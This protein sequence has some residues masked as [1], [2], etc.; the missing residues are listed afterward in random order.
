MLNAAAAPNLPRRARAVRPIEPSSSAVPA[1]MQEKPAHTSHTDKKEIKCCGNSEIQHEIFCDTSRKSEKH[2]Q[3]REISR[4]SRFTS[5]L[6][7]LTVL[8]YVSSLIKPVI[9]C[10]NICIQYIWYPGETDLQGY[11]T[12]GDWLAGV[13]YPGSQIFELKISI[14]QQ[15]LNQN[16]K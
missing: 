2:E 5:F 7:K 9:I 14:T 6:L 11:D 10:I 16:R 15:I 12:R 1:R 13:S 8:S 3:I 4:N